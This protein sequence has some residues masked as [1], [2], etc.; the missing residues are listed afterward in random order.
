MSNLHRLALVVEMR[1]IFSK[2]G[3]PPCS[4]VVNNTYILELIGDILS[5]PIT[6]DE[7]YFIRCETLWILTNLAF[8]DQEFDMKLILASQLNYTEDGIDEML[9][10]IQNDFQCK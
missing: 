3:E 9:H 6:T 2:A 1:N 4:E 5:L 8:V 10:D 7:L